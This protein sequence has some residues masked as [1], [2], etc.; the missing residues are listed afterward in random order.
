M[1]E[2]SKGL[3]MFFWSDAIISNKIWRLQWF[4]CIYF[5]L[6][7]KLVLIR[8][9]YVLNISATQQTIEICNI[10]AAEKTADAALIVSPSFYKGQMNVSTAYFPLIS[11]RF[12]IIVS[13]NQ[14]L[15]TGTMKI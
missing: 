8:R 10:V 1:D 11:F 12:P 5:Y 3:M 2:L 15:H 14:A 9:F 13:G 6:I 7:V 4:I